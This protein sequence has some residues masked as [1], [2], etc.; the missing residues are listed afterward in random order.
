MANTLYKVIE[1]LYSIKIYRFINKPL[2]L[3][4]GLFPFSV[5]EFGIYF[6]LLYLIY[7]ITV[8]IKNLIQGKVNFKNNKH[9]GKMLARTIYFIVILYL[10]FLLFWGLNYYRLPFSQTAGI[11]V[12]KYSKKDLEDLCLYLIEQANILREEIAEN[13][14]GVMIIPKGNKWLLENA[15]IGFNNLSGIYNTLS[16][17]YG[18]PKP[19]MLSELMCY[20][21]ISGIYFPFTAEA[22]ININIPYPSL[23]STITH[24]MAHQRGYAKEDE[25]NFIAYLA[26]ISNPYIEFKY[27]GTLLALIHSINELYKEDI[28]SFKKVKGD[29]SQGLSRDLD[30]INSF[31]KKYEGPIEKASTELNNAYLRANNQKD[32]VKSYGRVVD[33]LIAFYKT[34]QELINH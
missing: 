24:E 18:K 25:A 30:Y 2:S 20:T 9:L 7:R 13:N 33:L 11:K 6:I 19:V 10:S 16:G 26:S 5:A 31:W 27:S 17:E 14:Q 22:N 1:L 12:N 29:F 34:N 32:G 21:G 8:F 3:L 23:P 4:T 15:H 28:E